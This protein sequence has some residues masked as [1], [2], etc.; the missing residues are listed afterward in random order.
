MAL[1]KNKVIA[2][3]QRAVQRGQLDRGIKE[4]LTIVGEDRDETIIDLGIGGCRPCLS[5]DGK[6]IAWGETDHKVVIAELDQSVQRPKVGRRLL[7]IVD[8]KN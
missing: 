1:N 4:Y 5:P 3:A 8:E 7:E 2:A 6:R